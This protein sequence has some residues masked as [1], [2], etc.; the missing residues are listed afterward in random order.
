[1]KSCRTVRALAGVI[2]GLVLAGCASDP[3]QRPNAEQ[4]QLRAAKGLV[5]ARLPYRDDW[6]T[7]Y[8]GNHLPPKSLVRTGANSAADLTV[9][10]DGPLLRLQ[11]NSR[12]QL[13]QMKR[14][15]DGRTETIIDLQEG[16]A[17]VDDNT[18]KKGSFVEI[19]TRTGV[20]RIPPN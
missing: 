14:L 9:G 17:I 12:V 18:V 13:L 20:A 8:V 15:P 1:M 7:V 19:R 6:I 2:A 5:E 16:K 10:N 11:A 3:S 4:A